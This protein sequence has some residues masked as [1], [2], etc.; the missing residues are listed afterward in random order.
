MRSSASSGGDGGGS[1]SR[2]C[3]CEQLCTPLQRFQHLGVLRCGRHAAL[4]LR[5]VLLCIQSALHLVPRCGM[6]HAAYI[7]CVS[8]MCDI[9]AVPS[10]THSSA[11]MPRSSVKMIGLSKSY[12]QVSLAHNAPLRPQQQVEYVRSTKRKRIK[13]LHARCGISPFY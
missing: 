8:R 12:K 2:S 3:T 10:C 6:C 7:F 1:A 4:S 11:T 13:C 9:M 5:P